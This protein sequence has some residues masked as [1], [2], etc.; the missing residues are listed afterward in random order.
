[1]DLPGE[2]A[3]VYGL[4]ILVLAAPPKLGKGAKAIV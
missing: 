3:I 1:M 2:D 4:G